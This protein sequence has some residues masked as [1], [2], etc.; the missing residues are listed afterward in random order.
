M[1]QIRKKMTAKIFQNILIGVVVL[2][3][4]GAI[5]WLNNSYERMK[6]DCEK[7]GGSFYSISFT[8]NICVEGTIVHELK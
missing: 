5:L 8:Q 6:S 3:I 4:F 1:G 7:M 2:T